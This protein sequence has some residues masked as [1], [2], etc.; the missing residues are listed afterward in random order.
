MLF[1]HHIETRASIETQ[2]T[3]LQASVCT[4]CCLATVRSWI[5]KAGEEWQPKTDESGGE[6]YSESNL[7]NDQDG[8]LLASVG[9]V[10]KF[11]AML[12]MDLNRNENYHAKIPIVVVLFQIQMRQLKTD[13]SSSSVA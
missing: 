6:E 10:M 7:V 9:E 13:I 4:L 11:R 1:S 2:F 3:S 12:L 5:K 8:F